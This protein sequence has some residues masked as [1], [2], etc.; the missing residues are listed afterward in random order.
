MAA[1]PQ[2]WSKADDKV[3]KKIKGVCFDI[4]DTFSSH[5]KITPDAY[6][7]LWELKKAG[8][9]LVP[10]TG[11]P[12]G[13][14]DHIARF[15]PVDAVVGENGAFVFYMK[16][17]IRHRLD[18]P[19]GDTQAKAK[20]HKLGEK[21][22][23]KFPGALWASDQNYRENDLAIDICED[24]PA[25]EQKDVDALLDLCHA[26]GAHA[27]LSSIHVN[28]WYGDFDKKKGFKAWLDAG[29]P[30]CPVK[31]APNF[32]EWIYLGDSPNDEPLF[33]F[34]PAS[35]GVANLKLY[36][37]RLKHP[38][39]WMTA[40]ESGAGFTEVAKKLTSL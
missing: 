25:W 7:S 20:L 10:V 39:T 27:K 21:I 34:F 22:K 13:W 3:L 40:K 8:Y 4:D 17:G 2:E 14:C 1:K 12:A 5:G 26:E 6:A 36:L 24:V 31:P 33:E 23:S 29:A 11:R 38:P 35:V 18:T 19:G 15:W 37:D 30:G 32:E 16:D 9:V 28:T